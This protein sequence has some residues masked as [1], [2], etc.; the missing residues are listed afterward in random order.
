M[1]M[2]SMGA[3]QAMAQWY[4]RTRKLN[5]LNHHR[6]SLVNNALVSGT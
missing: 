3:R 1:E 4:Q 6:G 5:H 2:E